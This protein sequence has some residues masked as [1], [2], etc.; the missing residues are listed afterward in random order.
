MAAR[1]AR[2]KAEAVP[3]DN[4]EIVIAAD[5]VVVLDN[6]ILGKPQD[7]DDARR[8]LWA[9][10]GRVH[11]VHTGLAL[12]SLGETWSETDTALVHMR[13]YGADEIEA[14]IASG[15][16]LDKAGAYG[17]QNEIFSPANRVE[18]CYMTVVGLPL[19]RLA[20]ALMRWNLYVPRIPPD[21]CRSVLG[22]PCPA[23]LF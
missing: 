5:T 7:T 14:Y 13:D 20:R 21:G 19:C 11:L 10:R 15:L 3:L 1:L 9:L 17:I 23:A 18:G 4:G 6:E 12:R 16:P 2:L 22:R 8:M